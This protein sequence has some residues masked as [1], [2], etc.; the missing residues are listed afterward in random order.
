M[1]ADTK[2]YTHHYKINHR[3]S[4]KIEYIHIINVPIKIEKRRY[5]SVGLLFKIQIVIG[6]INRH[7][8][9]FNKMF[10]CCV[11]CCFCIFFCYVC[12]DRHL[13]NQVPN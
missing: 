4:Q 2:N 1:T 10:K 3:S 13:I 7:F 8:R 9:L 6:F 11:H 12:F 5:G